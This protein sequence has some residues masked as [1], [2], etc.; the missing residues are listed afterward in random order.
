MLP[1]T[2]VHAAI[3]VTLERSA[4]GSPGRRRP[5]TSWKPCLRGSKDAMEKRLL[6]QPMV[7]GGWCGPHAVSLHAL[8]GVGSWAVRTGSGADRG[9]VFRRLDLVAGGQALDE[10]E[11]AALLLIGV[12]LPYLDAL[13]GTP[14]WALV[15]H[16]HPYFM[17]GEHGGDTDMHARACITELV[18]SRRG[19]KGAA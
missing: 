9:A 1:Q 14:A 7:E 5:A 3:G 16:D 8:V 19:H 13:T 12:P 18:V 4:N 15:R 10:E 6:N 17:S 11:P 2:D